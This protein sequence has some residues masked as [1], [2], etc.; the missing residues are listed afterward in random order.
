[1]ELEAIC[2]D[3]VTMRNAVCKSSV[4]LV[5][6]VD[7]KA[8]SM[9]HVP[10]D[11][12]PSGI[13]PARGAYLPRPIGQFAL[14][15][16]KIRS[17]QHKQPVFRCDGV[18]VRDGTMPFAGLAAITHSL[19]AL[20]TSLANRIMPSVALMSEEM[21]AWLSGTTLRMATGFH[22]SFG[23]GVA[24][25]NNELFAKIASQY[26]ALVAMPVDADASALEGLPA[27]VLKS[28]A[29]YLR[30]IDRSQLE[31]LANWSD[32]GAAFVGYEYAGQARS[33]VTS[34]VSDVKTMV[35]VPVKKEKLAAR[36]F[37]ESF[38]L[39]RKQFEFYDVQ[40]GNVM[41]GR[42]DAA[43]ARSI[44]DAAEVRVG[45]QTQYDVQID[46]SGEPLRLTN[47]TP[48]QTELFKFPVMNRDAG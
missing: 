4:D 27:S 35:E 33:T 15:A 3:G 47:L 20:W 22:G 25:E 37:F 44:K 43:L 18:S 36:G 24:T 40:T 30:A 48:V 19:Q 1:M 6:Y 31:V 7:G 45:H 2:T 17:R 8:R 34:A 11:R 39:N 12:V 23:I 9:W 16:L 42:I 26:K 32:G 5:D 14:A 28:Y 38:G 46:A 41:T 21:S 29:D 10:P 13:L